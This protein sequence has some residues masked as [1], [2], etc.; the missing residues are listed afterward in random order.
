VASLRCSRSVSVFWWMRTCGHNS[1]HTTVEQS[2]Y[3][4]LVA[5]A[6]AGDEAVDFRAMRFAYLKSPARERARDGTTNLARL[7]DELF[8]A[9]REGDHVRVSG[10]A[11]QILSMEYVDLFGQKFLSQ[12]CAALHDDACAKQHRF[13]E[14]GLLRSI[15]STG[16]GA[17]CATAWEVITIQEEYF[18]LAMRGTKLLQQPLVSGTT[19]SCDEM[20]VADEQ[21]AEH[22]YYFN[23]DAVLADEAAGFKYPNPASQPTPKEGAAER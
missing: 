19:H 22:T 21:G 16:D 6:E 20:Q 9:A 1:H 4:K 18:V 2:D 5:Q 13:V 17:S 3:A 10:I 7:H 23:V 15:L 11:R 12:S 14:F 8:Q